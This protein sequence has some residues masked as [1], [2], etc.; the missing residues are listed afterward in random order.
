MRNKFEPRFKAKV[1]LAA[2]KGEQTTA[3]ISA[4][5]GVHASQ[6]SQWKQELLQRSVEIFSKPD[7]TLHV[8]QQEMAD[9]LHRT[10]GELKVENDWYKKKLEQ[11]G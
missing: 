10:I 7:R 4:E 6:I 8:Q 11:L 3:E 9:K 1:A 2:I 5:Y